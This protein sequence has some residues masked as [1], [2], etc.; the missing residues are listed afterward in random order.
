MPQNTIT[1]PTDILLTVTNNWNTD[2][3]VLTTDYVDI[4]NRPLLVFKEDPKIN[5]W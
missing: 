3:P 4:S 5:L 1:D 2:T